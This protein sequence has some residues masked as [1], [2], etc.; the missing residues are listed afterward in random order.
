MIIELTRGYSAI[1]DKEDYEKVNSYSWYANVSPEG[2]V[3]AIRVSKRKGHK[4]HRFVI[5]AKPGELV[6]HINGNTLDNRKRNLRIVS[7]TQNNANQK[8]HTGKKYSKFKGVSYLISGNRS[9]R[10]T[11]CVQYQGRVIR[12]GYFSTELEAHLA[13]KKKH[14]EI[15]GSYSYFSR[16]KMRN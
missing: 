14:L 8:P 3:Y 4:M 13:Y 10:W 5:A 1:V 11:S 12:L 16:G 6:D 2:H 9:K 15:Y 7:P